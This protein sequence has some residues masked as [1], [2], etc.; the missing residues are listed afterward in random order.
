[1]GNDFNLLLFLLWRVRVDSVNAKGKRI[2]H[3]VPDIAPV[4][5]FV[6]VGPPPLELSP[7]AGR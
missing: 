6:L 1:M 2:R 7:K 4:P 5:P 3:V